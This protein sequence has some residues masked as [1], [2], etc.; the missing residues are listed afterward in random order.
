MQLVRFA[1]RPRASLPEQQITET[2]LAEMANVAGDDARLGRIATGT[3]GAML[4]IDDI[5]DLPGKIHDSSE[6][7]PAFFEYPIWDS[8]Y[9]FAFVVGCFGVEW[10][11]RKRAGF[12]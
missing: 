9:L 3:G 8:G 10:A 11:M 1:A 2:S 7:L 5:A 12:V 6:K 4:A